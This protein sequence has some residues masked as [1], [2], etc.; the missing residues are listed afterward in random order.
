MSVAPLVEAR[1]V[2]V[3]RQHPTTVAIRL[4]KE[5]HVNDSYLAAQAIAGNIGNGRAG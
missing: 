1:E 2:P 3:V 4:R 5:R